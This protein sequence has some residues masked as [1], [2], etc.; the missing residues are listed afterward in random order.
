MVSRRHAEIRRGASGWS[1]RDLGSTNGTIVNGARLDR[2]RT[3][4]DGD[5]V[6]IGPWHFVFEGDT[7][8]ARR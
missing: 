3:L 7:L 4:A 2:P 8:T 5:S 6:T 1:I